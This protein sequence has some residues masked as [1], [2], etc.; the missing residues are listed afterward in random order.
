M[1]SLILYHSKR[2]LFQQLA[3]FMCID[4][5]LQTISFQN[6][7]ETHKSI[8]S[9]ENSSYF[10]FKKRDTHTHKTKEQIMKHVF[11][12]TNEQ[13]PFWLNLTLSMREIEIMLT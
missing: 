6:K 3:F 9:I 1:R 12:C 7:N 8:F 10:T 5:K 13:N 2:V 4:C 11:F